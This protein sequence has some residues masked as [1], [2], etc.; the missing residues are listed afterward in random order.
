MYE[1]NKPFRRTPD[2]DSAR[3]RAEPVRSG[4][5]YYGDPKQR[6]TSCV[7][8]LQIAKTSNQIIKRDSYRFGAET[9]RATMTAAAGGP[10]PSSREIPSKGDDA[11]GISP[12]SEVLGAE[13][14]EISSCA[15]IPGQKALGSVVFRL[16]GG[17]SP[18]LLVPGSRTCGK[19]AQLFARLSRCRGSSRAT[20]LVLRAAREYRDALKSLQCRPAVSVR[21]ARRAAAAARGR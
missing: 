7:S 2:A 8:R 15:R 16:R 9:S 3:R 20:L 19:N 12:S 17:L 4:I 6:T 13:P 21:S 14:G 5:G 11:A 1:E 18:T 10:C